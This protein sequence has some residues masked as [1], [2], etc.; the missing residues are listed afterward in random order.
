MRRDQSMLS[1]K[2]LRPDEPDDIGLQE[3]ERRRSLMRNEVY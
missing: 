1:A 2:S 3:T